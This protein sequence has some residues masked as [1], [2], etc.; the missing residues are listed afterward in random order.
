MYQILRSQETV[1]QNISIANAAES[2][3]SLID[4]LTDFDFEPIESVDQSKP[5][6]VYSPFVDGVINLDLTILSTSDNSVPSKID[7][8]IFGCGEPA[9]IVSK[10]VLEPTTPSAQTVVTQSSKN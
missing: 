8:S 1:I 5:S 7:L 10:P 6:V 2:K 4:A 9:A 3:I